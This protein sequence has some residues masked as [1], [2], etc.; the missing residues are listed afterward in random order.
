VGLDVVEA[1]RCGEDGF[2]LTEVEKMTY[3][4]SDMYCKPK[5]Y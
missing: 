3:D 4:M 2:H 5:K 1:E